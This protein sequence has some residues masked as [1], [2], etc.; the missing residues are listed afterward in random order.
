MSVSLDRFIRASSLLRATFAITAFTLT[1]AAAS[2]PRVSP[3]Q[4]HSANQAPAVAKIA[5]Q[6]LVFEANR[7]RHTPKWLFPQEKATLR[8]PLKF[9]LIRKMP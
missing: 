8:D 1:L 6:P 9:A 4:D 2:Q 5:E 7:G 3:G